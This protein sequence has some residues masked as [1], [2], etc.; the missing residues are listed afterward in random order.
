VEPVGLVVLAAGAS[1]RL[2]RPKALV[3]LGGASALQRLLAAGACCAGP[4]LPPLVIGGADHAALAAHLRA[5]VERGRVEL[6]LN[7][8]WAAGRT[9]SVQL[10]V[11]ARP[12]LDLVVAPVDVPLVPRR[13][14][15]ALLAEWCAAGAPHAGW[16]APSAPRQPGG[17]PHPGHPV[18]VGRA[19]LARVL[20]LAPD[21]PLT[22]LRELAGKKWLVQVDSERIHDDLDGPE[23]WERLR[24][25]A[26]S[27]P[28]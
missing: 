13:V 22:T 1:S 11:R 4:G 24:R 14:F 8:G 18:L 9:S 15:E 23:D 28:A 10:A 7:R 20:E 17:R 25:A 21:V 26:A 12:G 19:L 27:D 6:V 5:D 2:G 16:L 3:E